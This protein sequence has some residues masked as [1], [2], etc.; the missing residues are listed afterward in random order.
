LLAADINAR[1][2]E[3]HH[4]ADHAQHQSPQ[5]GRHGK[6]AY[7]GDDMQ[8]KVLCHGDLQVCLGERDAPVLAELTL[9]QQAVKRPGELAGFFND[10]LGFWLGCGYRAFGEALHASL[11]LGLALRPDGEHRN[12]QDEDRKSAGDSR[13]H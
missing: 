11:K 5:Q 2:K 7:H 9:G 10:F 4:T 12:N 3:A 6:E 1:D 13:D 8:P